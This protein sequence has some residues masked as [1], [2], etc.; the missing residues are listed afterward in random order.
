LNEVVGSVQWLAL[1]APSRQFL[2][3]FKDPAPDNRTVNVALI[4]Q[5]VSSLH[6]PYRRI[7]A[8][9]SISSFAARRM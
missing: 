8:C 6:G 1:S 7:L 3:R 9:W 2:N 5:H 4:E